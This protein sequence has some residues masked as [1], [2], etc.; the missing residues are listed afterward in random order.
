MARQSWNTKSE[1]NDDVNKQHTS[2]PYNQ[3]HNSRDQQRDGDM[4]K[5]QTIKI[6]LGIRHAIHETEAPIH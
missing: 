5:Q 4:T 1:E 6:E 2:P 3:T